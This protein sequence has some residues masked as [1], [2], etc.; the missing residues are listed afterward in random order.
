WSSVLLVALLRERREDEVG[1]VD[2]H[3]P[4]LVAHGV[5]VVGVGV[6][7]AGAASVPVDGVGATPVGTGCT[8]RKG[9]FVGFAFARSSVA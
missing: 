5:G 6:G 8:R 1:E 3:D 9:K 7:V 2:A 4:R